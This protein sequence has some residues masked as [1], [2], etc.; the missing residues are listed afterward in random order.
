M[1]CYYDLLL[2]E[3]IT[4]VT[5]S[6]HVFYTCFVHEKIETEEYLSL[7]VLQIKKIYTRL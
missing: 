4:L 2:F 3:N 7:G 6:V 5:I 1:T